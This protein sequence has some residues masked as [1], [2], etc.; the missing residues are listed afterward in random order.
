M[1]DSDEDV[2]PEAGYVEL[3]QVHE[4]LT[5]AARLLD[6]AEPVVDLRLAADE[7]QLAFERL[8][9][10]Y[11]GIGD[12][13][14]AIAAVR[15]HVEAA[16]AVLAPGASASA[17][18]VFLLENLGHA[19]RYCDLASDRLARVP[20][21]PAEPARVMV[22]SGALPCLHHIDRPRL[23]PRIDVPEPPTPQVLASPPESEPAPTT[24]EEL[25]ELMRQ[26]RER[27]EARRRASRAPAEPAA[28]EPAASA[29]PE[30][31]SVDP[32]PALSEAEFTLQRTRECFEEVAM[33]GVLRA[34]IT[35]DSW[36]SA[37]VIE[38]RMFRNVDAIVAMGP[39][40]VGAVESLVMDTPVRDAS[41]V[42][43]AAVVLGS[44]TGRD[45]L[46]AAERVFAAVET[47]DPEAGSVLA[48]ALAFVPNPFVPLVLRRMLASAASTHRATAIEAMIHRGQATEDD[49]ARAAVDEPA[50]ARVALPVLAM[51]AHP[52]T[53]DSIARAL[54]QAD[55]DLRCA[56]WLAMAYSA[57]P[58]TTSTLYG[59]LG[60]ERASFATRLLAICGAAEDAAKLLVMTVR[61][62]T[63]VLVDAVGWAGASEAVPSLI[64]LM[65]KGDKKL[66]VA[67]AE[68]LARITGARLTEEALVPPEDLEA[69]D[70]PEPNT[71]EP[72]EPPLAQLVGD[73]RDAPEHGSPDKIVRPATDWQ[74]WH[75]WWAAN[76]Q[77]F[78]AG[79]RYRRGSPYSALVSW[80]ELDRG[81]CSP[82]ERRWLQRE[83]VL[84][85]GG[86]APLD[87][88]DLVAH[89]VEALSAWEPQAR[90]G[91][92]APGTWLVPRR[93]RG[94]AP[95]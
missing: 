32:L 85:S 35:G 64:E 48:A 9:E 94:Y 39:R 22:A 13:L 23:V 76:R 5:Q 19:Q 29:V 63:P 66:G 90:A 70:V 24:F 41:R 91:S 26:R 83:L 27:A 61:A 80:N 7:V 38:R 88:G 43:G 53:R 8:Y 1:A 49:V 57:H 6:A 37:L 73:A 54:A 21:R 52:T 59:E 77:R 2:V 71:G 45:A 78:L 81:P 18:I 58:N 33:A 92:T 28:D 74:R 95:R 14:R 17:A 82:D 30:G 34:P 16:A 62:P 55:L 15:R 72:P 31:F 44:V 10:A 20:V 67:I 11:D 79:T 89:Q 60:G 47:A 65:R 56:A 50:V 12:P 86:Y 46:A 42:W 36:K 69:P 4:Q 75:D 68:A 25:A 3:E 87:P 51:G 84:R 93:T 40:A